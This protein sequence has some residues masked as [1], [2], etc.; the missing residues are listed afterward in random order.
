MGYR[1]NGVL[2]LDHG[3]RL[4]ADGPR[5]DATILLKP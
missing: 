3:T 1:G 4:L 5:T 2:K